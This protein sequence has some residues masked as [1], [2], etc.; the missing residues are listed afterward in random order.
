MLFTFHTYTAVVTECGKPQDINVLHVLFRVRELFYFLSSLQ[1]LM[2]E[3]DAL[4]RNIK[5]AEERVSTLHLPGDESLKEAS[6]KTLKDLKAKQNKMK[7]DANDK[8]QNLQ[9]VKF[10]SVSLYLF[11]CL[12][13]GVCV[14]ILVNP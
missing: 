10:S 6:R 5:I 3:L 11:W 8:L 4:D 12:F 2:K 13:F 1:D 9:V 7:K 14:L